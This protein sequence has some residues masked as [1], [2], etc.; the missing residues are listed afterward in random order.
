MYFRNKLNLMKKQITLLFALAAI[1][2]STQAQ[3]LPKRI[4]LGLHTGVSLPINTDYLIDSY[5][6][7]GVS[8]GI[9]ADYNFK[10]NFSIG[11]EFYAT[12]HDVD[13]VAIAD[14][15]LST[16]SR[17]FGLNAISSEVSFGS[18]EH[19]MTMLNVKYN[20]PLTSRFNMDFGLGLGGNV[21]FTPGYTTTVNFDDPLRL[22]LK[23]IT[24]IEESSGFAIASKFDL[25]FRYNVGSALGIRVGAQ[26][27]SST[28]L[29]YTTNVRR[30]EMDD[31]FVYDATIRAI[32]YDYPAMW[33]N[34]SL[35]ITYSFWSRTN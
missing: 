30:S 21:F 7:P 12:G 10:K 22:N 29:L 26:F 27:F 2:L 19:Y 3:E 8:F 13:A 5:A 34:F 15:L 18:Y 9:N 35:G 11:L 14:D 24:E 1:C 28:N 16:Q 23:E 6:L 25:G 20:L 33:L 17:N 31:L 4:T 32:E